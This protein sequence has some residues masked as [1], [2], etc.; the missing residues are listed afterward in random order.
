MNQP[1]IFGPCPPD[2][3]GCACHIN[4]PCTHC[5]DHGEDEK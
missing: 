1:T 4:P 2:C 3:G 5:M